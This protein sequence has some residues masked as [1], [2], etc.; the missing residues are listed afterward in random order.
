MKLYFDVNNET[1][2]FSEFVKFGIC[3][4]QNVSA[5]LFNLKVSGVAMIHLLLTVAIF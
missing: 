3:D 2:Q 5:S 1:L 4:L